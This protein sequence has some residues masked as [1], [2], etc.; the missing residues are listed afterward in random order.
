MSIVY[1][2]FS[3]RDHRSQNLF[4]HKNDTYLYIYLVSILRVVIQSTC[5]ESRDILK[6]IFLKLVFKSSVKNIA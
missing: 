3:E 2:F 1:F 5:P 4:V 6:N